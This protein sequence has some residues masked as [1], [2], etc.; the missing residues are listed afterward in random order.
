VKSSNPAFASSAFQNYDYAARGGQTMTVQGTVAKTF[1]MLG[2]LSAT[3][4][5][6]WNEAGNRA[7]TP[8]LIGGAAIGGFV[9]ALITFFRPTLAS[10]TAP[11]YAALEG[12]LL[13][14]LSQILNA[15]Y[16]GIALQA[17]ALT[18]G[19]MLIMLTLYATRAIRV[20]EK[21][22]M[23]VVAATGALMLVYLVTWIAR[24]FFHTD[25]PFIHES[26][27][28]GIIFSLFVVGLAAF[29]LL[30]DFDQIEQGAAYGAPK[31]MEWYGSFALMVTLI[32]LYVEVLNLLRKVY[33][34]RR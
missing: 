27:K 16:P 32:W 14:A 2:I 29:N 25:I 15:R 22:Y 28:I 9:V 1:L 8:G 31:S 24:L 20:T 18:S 11:V 17:V 34:N 5:W 33:D 4:I 19:T 3:A 30:L 13:G 7:M 10:W 26:G 23:G 6:A 21:L 12:V